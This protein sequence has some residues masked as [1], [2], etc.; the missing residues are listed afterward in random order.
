MLFKEFSLGVAG[1]AILSAVIVAPIFEELLFR[2]I[3][4]SWLV[5]LFGR[6]NTSVTASPPNW[7]SAAK[8][9]RSWDADLGSFEAVLPN[10]DPVYSPPKPDLAEAAR[11]SAE[12][13]RRS[14]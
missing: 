5:R 3:L 1:L 6:R 7:Q 4:Q 13:A 11:P 2:G 10:N 8:N 9:L 14:F 12:L